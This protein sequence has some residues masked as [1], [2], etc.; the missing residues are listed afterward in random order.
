M[1]AFKISDIAISKL[2]ANRGQIEGLP[3]NPRIIRDERFQKLTKSIQDDPEMLS[4]RE[5]IVYPIDAGKYVV[6][7]G[8]M[9]LKAMQ[10]LGYKTAPCKELPKE[11]PVEKLKAYTI[12]DNVPFGDTD[13][14]AIAEDWDA[15]ELAEWGLEVLVFEGEEEREQQQEGKEVAHRSLQD[16][17][18][19]PPFSVLDTRQGYWRERKQHWRALIGDNGESREGLINEIREYKKDKGYSKIYSKE[20]V[21]PNSATNGVSILDPVLAELAS[22]WFGLPNSNTFDPFA[23]DSVFGY[24]SSYLGNRFTGIELRREQADLNN[25]RIKGFPSKYICDDGQ[26]VLQHIAPDSQDLLFSCPPYFDLEVYSDLQNDASNQK[27]YADFLKILKN[28]FTSAV[29]CLRENRF[30]VIVVGDVRDRAGFY[31]R[32][33]DD[34]KDIFAASGMLLYNEL[35]LVEALG[36]LPQRV[37]KFMEHRKIGKCHQNVLVFYKG[38]P[39]AIK[40]V[41]HKLEFSTT[42]ENED[43]ESANV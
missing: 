24:V 17:F 5:L 25:E 43:D 26:N 1:A 38:K 11:T 14:E 41:F 2:E 31:R 21:K 23:G 19:V 15:E 16:S 10:E 12:K 6:I 22:L 8:N 36:T 40:G 39:K 28:A 7:A 29:Q 34:I 18:I 13:W 33:V 30:A 35:I 42:N 9:R 20:R 3:K 4:L 32:F 37:A 27:E